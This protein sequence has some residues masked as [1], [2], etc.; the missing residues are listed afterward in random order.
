MQ[1]NCYY[2]Q[3]AKLYDNKKVKEDCSFS[4]PL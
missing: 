1:H 4:Y 3:P 2:A